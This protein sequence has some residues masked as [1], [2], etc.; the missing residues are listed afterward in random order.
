MS[1]NKVILLGNVGKDPD[2]RYLDNHVCVANLTLATTE[3]AYTTQNGTQV[4]ERTEWH[5]LVFWRGLAETVEKYVHKG[6]KLYV[7][8]SLRTRSY[9]DQ[10]GLRRYATEVFVENM[11]MLTLR[12]QRQPE[13]PRPQQP[14]P[15]QQPAQP[16]QAPQQAQ[17]PQQPAESNG[18]LPF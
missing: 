2:V 15:V 6:D 14:Q 5:N 8:G 11:E 17:N 10:N 13:A 7:E 4:P 9:E 3:R 16:T 12:S 18:G 1:V